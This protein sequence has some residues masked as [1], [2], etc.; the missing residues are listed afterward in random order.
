MDLL[1][2]AAVRVLR[3]WI[4]QGMVSLLWAHPPSS[5][6]TIEGLLAWGHTPMKLT[7]LGIKS[8]GLCIHF[9]AWQRNATEPRV[10][11]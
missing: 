11:S 9:L 4:R 10:G 3:N 2:P 7:S 6:A 8:D 1:Q 5:A